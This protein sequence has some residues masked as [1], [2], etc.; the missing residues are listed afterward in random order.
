MTRVEIKDGKL[1]V[2]KELTK[3][4]GNKRA[5][6]VY[7]DNQYDQLLKLAKSSGIEFG[8]TQ[9]SKTKAINLVVSAIIDSFIANQS[10]PKTE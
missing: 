5:K 4:N 1:I 9:A 2:K 6:Y 7:S 8:S 10:K 3:K